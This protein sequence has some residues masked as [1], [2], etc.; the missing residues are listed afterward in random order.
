MT[1]PTKNQLIALTWKLIIATRGVFRNRNGPIELVNR[2]VSSAKRREGKT[3]TSILQIY[4]TDYVLYHYVHYSTVTKGIT[5][6]YAEKKSTLKNWQRR[7]GDGQPVQRNSDEINEAVMVHTKILKR[8]MTSGFKS[9]CRFDYEKKWQGCW[10]AY[11]WPNPK[12]TA[13]FNEEGMEF[14]CY[15]N[16]KVDEYW[17]PRLREA[18][19]KRD[20]FQQSLR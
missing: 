1:M 10:V 2:F 11:P 6:T 18:L 13:T 14:N 3:N 15:I 20:S 4:R 8:D 19:K 12:T 7:F 9:R 17:V 16:Q 5:E